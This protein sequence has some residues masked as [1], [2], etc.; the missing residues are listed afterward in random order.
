VRSPPPSRIYQDVVWGKHQD[1]SSSSAAD[2]LSSPGADWFYGLIL[3]F[4]KFRDDAWPWLE[5]LSQKLREVDLIG[6]A[7]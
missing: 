6:Q 3:A 5:Q 2:R 4:V 1:G 7:E